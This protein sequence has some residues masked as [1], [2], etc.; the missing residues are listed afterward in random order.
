MPLDVSRSSSS[1]SAGTGTDGSAGGR[2]GPN[3]PRAWLASDWVDAGQQRRMS[4]FTQYAVAA[5]E[6]ALADAGWRP[7]SDEDRDRLRFELLL[8]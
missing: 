1:S 3:T 6:M 8:Q 7:T 5:A 4:L 2:R